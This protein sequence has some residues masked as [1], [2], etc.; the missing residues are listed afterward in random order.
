MIYFTFMDDREEQDDYALDIN[1]R[2]D[3][4]G[5]YSSDAHSNTHTQIH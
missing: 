4:R 3:I 2:R 5:K 1:I